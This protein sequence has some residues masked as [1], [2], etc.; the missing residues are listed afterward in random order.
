MP[1]GTDWIVLGDQAARLRVS[2][3]YVVLEDHWIPTWLEISVNGRPNDGP[4]PE[5]FARVEVNRNGVP[6]LVEFA[7]R[8]SDPES[9]GIRQADFREVEVSALVEELVAGFTFRAQRGPDGES[10][11]EPPLEGSDAYLEALR[12][13]GR[14]RAGRTS[15]DIT[16]ELL[17]RVARVYRSNIDRHP[18]KAVEHHFQV[19]QRMAAE[20]VSRAR[21]RG[22]LPP[23][24]RGQKRA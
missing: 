5:G 10:I 2:R 12:F 8:A 1:N 20:Y 16:P 3:E 17:E 18:T 4:D 15:R 14:R 7:F 23:T 6:R 24:K 11:V 19:S 21:K 22:L 9:Q 13:I